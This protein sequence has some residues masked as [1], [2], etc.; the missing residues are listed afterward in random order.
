MMSEKKDGGPAYP[1]KRK[2]GF[3]IEPIDGMNT[4][5][6]DFEDVP[7]MTMRQW[8]AGRATDNDVKWMQEILTLNDEPDSRIA[9]KFA[10]AD[11][12]IDHEEHAK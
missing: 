11:A 5:V 12:M 3:H 8:Y 6:D 1:G 4:Q 2:N 7:G 10:Y 9:A